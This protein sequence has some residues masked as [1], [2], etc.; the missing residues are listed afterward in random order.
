MSAFKDILGARPHVWIEIHD[1][2]LG[3]PLWPNVPVRLNEYLAVLPR[4]Q[5]V[6]VSEP[7]VANLRDARA[8]G[9]NRLQFS[10]YGPI[11]AQDAHLVR[12]QNPSVCF[13]RTCAPP[14]APKRESAEQL[15]LRLDAEAAEKAELQ[16][17]L[18]EMKV[19]AAAAQ[20]E[21]AE[22]AA[23]LAQLEQSQA[24]EAEA[25]AEPEPAEPAEPEP[26][27][28]PKTEPKKGKKGSKS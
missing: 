16:A 9:R 4:G 17:Q 19:Q 20:A 12:L 26:A 7:L 24:A 14:V 1:N 10:E 25:K 21:A 27:P 18:E 6:L 28:E 13:P 2:P 8:A 3:K 22:N 23:K 11:D 15:A 5:K